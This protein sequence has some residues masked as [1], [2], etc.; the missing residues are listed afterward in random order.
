VVGESESAAGEVHAVRWVLDGAGAPGPAA[1]LGPGS[2]A[3]VN[4]TRLAGTLGDPAQAVALDLRNLALA[5]ALTAG[6]AEPSRAL[7]MNAAHKT[8]GLVG[9]QGFVA[10]P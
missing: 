9:T 7:G 10:V 3:A 1:D 4:A 8:V 5:E 2:A 6:A